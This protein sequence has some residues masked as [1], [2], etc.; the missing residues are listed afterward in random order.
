MNKKLLF[1]GVAT[2]AFMAG[3]LGAQTAPFDRLDN[4]EGD[5][6]D[7]VFMPV[8]PMV[9]SPDETS[10]YAVNAH[11]SEVR[12]F[13]GLSGSP[14]QTYAVPWGPVSIAYWEAPD[15]DEL[16]VVSRGTHALTRIDPVSG[17]V[18]NVLELPSEPGGVLLID[19]HLFV[20]CS[21]DDVVVQVY[22]PTNTIVQRFEIE[23]SR[24][25]LF[26]SKEGS[27][28]LVTPMLS[29]NNTGARKDVFANSMVVRTHSTEPVMNLAPA[30]N[31]TAQGLPDNDLFR[32]IPATGQVQVA[33]KRLGTNLFAHGI[34]PTT[35]KFWVLNTHA[36]NHG[37]SAKGVALLKNNFITSRITITT[38]NAP[39]S[40]QPGPGNPPPPPNPPPPAISHT[41]VGLDNLNPVTFAPG[42]FTAG[43]N[44]TKP[45]GLCF[46]S[47]GFGIIAGASTDRVRIVNQNGTKVAQWAL[48]AGSIPRAVL[49]SELNQLTAIYCWGTNL[50]DLRTNSGVS[51]A[52][53]QLGY[54]PSP[55][56][57]KAGRAIFFDAR[58]SQFENATCESCH[59]EGLMDFLVWD[60]SSLPVDDKGPMFTQ[61]LR[62][63]API[64]PYHW[65][66]EQV[67]L[68]DFNGVFADLFGSTPLSTGPG[69]DFEKLQAYIFN[70]ENPAN[71]NEHPERVISNDKV[72]T[73]FDPVDPTH[74]ALSAI[75]GQTKYFTQ[76]NVG[77]ATCQDCHTLPTGTSSDIFE[78]AIG[79]QHH[80]ASFDIPA[81]NGLWRKEQKSRVTVTYVGGATETRAPLGSGMSNGGLVPGLFEFVRDLFP[82]LS[83]NTKQDI[84]FFMHQIDNGLA[85][86]VHRVGFI[87]PGAASGASVSSYL[88]PEAQKRN[89]DIAVIGKVNWQGSPRKLRWFWDR[90]LLPTP[91]FACEDPS[92][93]NQDLAFFVNQ[94]GAGTGR[95][96]FLGLP[97]GMGRRWA[98][99]FDDDQ[100]FNGDEAVHGFNPTNPDSDN[101]G[102]LD[103]TEVE[104]VTNDP[105][106]LPNDNVAPTISVRLVYKTARIAK[107]IVETGEPTRLS[108]T[109]SDGIALPHVLPVAG[110]KRLHTVLLRDLEP[111]YT[112]TSF[113]R[114][115]SGTVQAFD[116]ANNP[117]SMPLPSFSTESF[118]TAL[119]G[120]PNGSPRENIVSN[121]T[122]PTA[123]PLATGGFEVK[124]HATIADFK[125]SSPM[126]GPLPLANHV[127]VGRVIFNGQRLDTF[128]ANGSPAP[129]SM[130]MEPFLGLPGYNYPSSGYLIGSISHV[131]DPNFIDGVSTL[132]FELP[133]A[134]PGDKV[135]VSIETVGEVDGTFDPVSPS[136]LGDSRFE[137]P[138]TP[139][140]HQVSAEITL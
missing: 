62:G 8:N 29:G 138:T 43:D 50:I 102:F 44:V 39:G 104:L 90:S 116:Q 132:T 18:L 63:I 95:N 91:L 128:V 35:G 59:V 52:Q 111:S 76:P 32:L 22:L 130:T 140:A 69:S 4:I 46:T 70:L 119:E 84:A 124:C 20:A 98:V 55:P 120:G 24:H 13:T 73:K 23:T 7:L 131:G 97:V 109:Y 118:I 48:P 45:Y 33:A 65:R 79:D 108:V 81:Y 56:I 49:Y 129:Q 66:G 110:W 94:A 34:H 112:T 115:Y 17:E 58:H 103:R 93:P 85:P 5:H 113:V 133:N 38:L 42:P 28:V 127:A 64:R 139:K 100:L 123:I 37:A 75:N 89:C 134:V 99:D 137:F 106:Y 3:S 77:P 54:D 21:A 83:D 136:F 57:V 125:R 1:H 92:I 27:N 78:D 60:N 86:A 74:G 82:P 2:F 30:G 15:H 80:R 11:G 6:V 114:T 41:F 12:R 135:K 36:R 88:I 53:L 105:L 40:T 26:L 31:I 72:L 67:D 126:G 47:S 87:G 71:P 122:V 117:I 25:L 10:L 101:D 9:L 96:I 68:V 51:V 107:I 14:A 16:L 121:L 61:S 19:D